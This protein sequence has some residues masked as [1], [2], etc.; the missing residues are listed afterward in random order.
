MY[1]VGA[2]DEFSG[3]WSYGDKDEIVLKGAELDSKGLHTFKI[4]IEKVLWTDES[5][6]NVGIFRTDVSVIEDITH[7]VSDSN[8]S[9][10]KFETRSYFDTVTDFEYDNNEKRVYFQIPFDWDDEIISHIPVV[11]IEV[12]F[13]DNFTEFYSPGYTG[14]ANGID[15]FKSSVTIDDYTK[16]DYRIVH[17]VLLGDHLQYIKNII[18]ETD[19]ISDDITFTLDLNDMIEFPFIATTHDE[20]FQ[21][22]LSWTPLEISQ[23]EKT[24]FIFTIRD[25]ST[26]EPLRHSSYN[27]IIIQSGQ[28]IYE[29]SG[30]AVVGGDYEE[31]TFAKGQTG[32]TVI[33]FADIRGTG[34]ETEFGVVV[35]PELGAP[36]LVLAAAV[37]ASAIL[38]RFRMIRF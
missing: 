7:V 23:E 33:R 38:S 36:L 16:E 26:G 20:Q 28:K 24:R 34:Q 5:L 30:T 6:D 18:E 9:F 19:E 4:G 2:L 13:P 35:I 25:G 37:T 15:L 12:R 3:V 8:G 11:H 32:P 21:I 1:G 31:Y 27:F 22:D 29:T 17:F 10:V 14:D